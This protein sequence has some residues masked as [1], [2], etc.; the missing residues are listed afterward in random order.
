MPFDGS[1][2]GI[3]Y[4][5]VGF[6]LVRDHAQLVRLPMVDMNVNHR[7][8]AERLEIG[9]PVIHIQRYLEIVRV[10]ESLERIE[11]PFEDER[12]TRHLPGQIQSRDLP[13]NHN[14]SVLAVKVFEDWK[15]LTELV[16]F[17]A[18]VAEIG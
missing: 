9:H 4:L 10:V 3:E 18:A 17:M 5:V 8:K 15:P 1:V 6:G 14:H 2:A 12:Q 7:S 11:L 16:A 13:Q